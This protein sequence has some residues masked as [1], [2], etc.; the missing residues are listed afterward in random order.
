MKCKLTTNQDLNI[1]NWF[2]YEFTKTR[3]IGGTNARLHS[4]VHPVDLWTSKN[5]NV[6]W[7][8]RGGYGY[9]IQKDAFQA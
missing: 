4:P 8:K 5:S 1:L 9:K 7:K 2:I 6:N 3:R